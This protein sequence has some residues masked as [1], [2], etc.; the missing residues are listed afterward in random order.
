[1]ASSA[2]GATPPLR[3]DRTTLFAVLGAGLASALLLLWVL[4]DCCSPASSWPC[5]GRRRRCCCFSSACGR[6]R[7]AR[8]GDARL[9][10]HPRRDRGCRAAGGDHRSRRADGVRQPAVRRMVQPLA[11]APR[12]A[13]PGDGGRAPCRRRPRGVARRR[14]DGARL[15]RRSAA[16][17]MCGCARRPARRSSAV[18]LLARQAVDLLAEARALIEGEAAGGWPRP[19]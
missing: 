19:G 17:S 15:R 2:Q 1:M 14:G 12:P 5:S 11:G 9:V 6:W 13:A 8:A 3:L 7:A 16:A 4:G 18:A 10:A